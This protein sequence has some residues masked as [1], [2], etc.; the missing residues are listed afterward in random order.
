VREL[1]NVIERL[2]LLSPP[3]RREPV[4]SGELHALLRPIRHAGAQN[5]PS[6]SLEKTEKTHILQV[7]AEQQGNKTRAARLLGIDYK[8][9]LAKLKKYGSA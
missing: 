1:R 9:L 8:T 7:L 3:D 6:G 4:S 2:L 5:A